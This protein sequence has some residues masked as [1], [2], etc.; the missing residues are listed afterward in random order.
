MRRGSLRVASTAR[1]T[2]RTVT[3]EFRSQWRI[4]RGLFQ[5]HMRRNSARKPI[6]FKS[7]VCG[8]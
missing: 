5:R 8:E 7:I 1:E 3:A 2:P 6:A 4:A